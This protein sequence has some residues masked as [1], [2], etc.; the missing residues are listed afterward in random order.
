MKTMLGFCACCWADTGVLANV[1]AMHV[2][3]RAHQISLNERMIAFLT[4]VGELS[5]PNETIRHNFNGEN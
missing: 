4:V 2:T 3:T 5:A 1:V